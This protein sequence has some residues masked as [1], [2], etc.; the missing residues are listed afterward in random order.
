VCAAQI[1]MFR[2]NHNQPC[3]NVESYCL[4]FLELQLHC[5]LNNRSAPQK[6][7]HQIRKIPKLKLLHDQLRSN[8]TQELGTCFLRWISDCLLHFWV[9][10]GRSGRR[11]LVSMVLRLGLQPAPPDL[12]GRPSVLS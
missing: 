5:S 10:Y 8:I 3:C 7:R 6:P 9:T 12:C 11:G 2:I 4:W 1:S